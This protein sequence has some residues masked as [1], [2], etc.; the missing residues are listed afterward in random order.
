MEF[1]LYLA[2]AFLGGY[3]VGRMAGQWGKAHISPLWRKGM[4]PYMRPEDEAAYYQAHK[5]D[6]DIWGDPI[7]A[8]HEAA[9]VWADE[10]YEAPSREAHHGPSGNVSDERTHE[11]EREALIE[12]LKARREA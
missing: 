6:P 8:S 10:P 7:E 12:A 2:G 9:Y 3:V 11:H 4:G 1:A 5:D